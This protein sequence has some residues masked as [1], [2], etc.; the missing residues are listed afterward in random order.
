MFASMHVCIL[1]VCSA[2]RN[3]KKAPY[4]LELELQV[5]VSSPVVSG[6]SWEPFG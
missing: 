2:H 3:Q 1:Y 4:A 6:T 5:V